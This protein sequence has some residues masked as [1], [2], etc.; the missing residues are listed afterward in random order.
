MQNDPTRCV[1]VTGATKGIGLATAKYFHSRGFSVAAAGRDLESLRP[2][3]G[4]SFLPV[5]MDVTDSDSVRDAA[6]EILEKL[7]PPG[8]VVN[9]AGVGFPGPLEC[10]TTEELREQFEVNVFGAHRVTTTFLP[11]M[12]KPGGRIVNVSSAAGRISLPNMGAYCASK[13]ALEALSD[14]LRLELRPSGLHVVVVEP[15][16]IST[17]FGETSR[18]HLEAVRKRLKIQDTGRAA[19]VARR[20]SRRQKS[21]DRFR[22]PPEAVAAVIYRAATSPRPRR[23]YRVTLPAWGA[24]LARVLPSSITDAVLGSVG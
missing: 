13:F 5:Y 4:E 6:E 8:I 9:N 22:R 11:W 24:E 23:R 20:D 2:I 19:E 16:P 7:G 17:S 14:A 21:L 18:R 15:G 3:A 12:P 1:L 10:L